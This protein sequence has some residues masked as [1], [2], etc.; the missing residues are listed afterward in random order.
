[1]DRGTREFPLIYIGHRPFGLLPK[2]WYLGIDLSFISKKIVQVVNLSN[3]TVFQEIL[4]TFSLFVLSYL[5]FEMC[6]HLCIK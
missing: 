4:K 2:K 1:M 5:L 6:S 3:N